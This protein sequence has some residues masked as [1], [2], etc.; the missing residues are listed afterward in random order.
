MFFFSV[1]GSNLSAQLQV[2]P[3]YNANS[4]TTRASRE[5]AVSDTLKLPFIENFVSMSTQANWI[6]NN[7]TFINNSYGKNQPSVGVATLDGVN[8]LGTPYVF[9]SEKSVATGVGDYLTSKTID[10]SDA[11][12]TDGLALSFFWQQGTPYDPNRNPLWS[13]GER[14]KVYFKKP[15][16]E[17]VQV[18][19]SKEV[20]NRIVATGI[21]GDTF[22]LENVLVDPV[23]FHKG[24]QIKFEYYGVLFGNY[25][26]FNVDNIY[27]DKGIARFG[28]DT[29]YTE[30]K[31]YAFSHKPSNLLAKY[32][33]I[34]IGHFK[35]APSTVL[36]EK[37]NAS[38]YSLDEQFVQDTD[39]SIVITDKGSGTRLLVGE[40]VEFDF[41][42]IKKAVPTYIS[43]TLD[44]DALKQKIES[45]MSDKPTYIQTTVS[46]LTSDSVFVTDS[47][48]SITTFS[49]YYAYDD[50]SMEA[51][52]GVIGVG[53]FV[54]AYDFVKK[55][56]LNGF[57]IYFPKYGLNLDDTFI[58]FNVYSALRGV[59]GKTADVRI[60]TQSGVVEYSS[61][62]NSLNKFIFV[63]FSSPLL[64]N[65]GRYYIGVS[66]DSQNSI[67]VGTDNA[68][69]CSKDIYYRS[70]DDP[71]KSF[72]SNYGYGC[73]A[74][75]PV[76]ASENLAV[77]KQTKQTYDVRLFP[78]PARDKVFFDKD[79]SSVDVFTALGV[80][81]KSI[82]V[83]DNQLDISDFNSGMYLL[84]VTEGEFFTSLKLLVD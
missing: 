60:L 73:A 80:F 4:V 56:A 57:Y 68:K 7:G 31:D 14:L 2:F 34:P 55:D 35:D 33:S 77:F 69:D 50:G 36:S 24:F 46:V 19:P 71:W 48:S 84:N 51:G 37:I 79:V 70:F 20:V 12:A 8:G 72:Y 42:D 29:T 28:A 38:V 10:I 44:R 78:N 66:Q 43:W 23:Y 32:S 6:Q 83:E 13:T 59:D 16:E 52:M 17:F 65:G 45:V 1:L 54:Q 5:T 67:L 82:K 53:E 21:V 27:L 26:V 9:L 18:W 76:V 41:E 61:D 22:Y 49:N 40:S 62:S 25:A 47:T 64:V 11:K 30:Q 58:T 81:V 63:P 74:I 39:S 75:R 3:I 15:N